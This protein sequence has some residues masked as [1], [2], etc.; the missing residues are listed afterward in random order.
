MT[1]G[2][3]R[4]IRNNNP[5]NIRWGD[6]WRGLV[7]VTKRTDSAFCQFTTPEFGIRALVVIL[8]NYSKKLGTPG[9]GG[10]NIDTV[11]EIISR[12]APPI[13]NDTEAYIRSVAKRVG[14]HSDD[15]I[16]LANQRIMRDLVKGIIAHENGSQPYSDEQIA[17]AMAMAL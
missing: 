10:K 1:T 9:V 15:P 13:E 4:G 2:S 3:V 17:N 8:K 6:E 14:V 7:P 5:G 16:D 12:W 11:R